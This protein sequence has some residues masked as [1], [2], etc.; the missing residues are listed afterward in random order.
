VADPFT[1]GARLYRTGDRVRWGA[2]GTLAFLGR[3]DDQVKIRGFRVEPGEVE[4]VLARHPAVRECAVAVRGDAAGERRLVAYLAA[5]E[6]DLAAVREAL[7]AAVPEH[8]V[9]SAWVVLDA[10]PLTPNG[11]VDRRALPAPGAAGGAEHVAP[12]TPVEEVLAGVWAEVLGAA[13]VGVEDD[14]FALGGHS[15]MA[16]R[17]AARVRA[18]FGVELPIRA[19]FAG[20][21]LGAMADTIERS[22]YADILA[23]PETQAEQQLAHINPS[24]EG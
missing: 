23:M 15:L 8:M 22:I 19:V 7:R 3:L 12:R 5:E 6:G 16:M 4:A 20:S 14:F 2:D 9:P 18:A 24:T 11:K 10:L 1:P 21:T 13:R 17:L